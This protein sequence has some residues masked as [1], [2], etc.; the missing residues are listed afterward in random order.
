VE[1]VNHRHGCLECSVIILFNQIKGVNMLRPRN[2]KLIRKLQKLSNSELKHL[3][4]TNGRDK[5]R[6]RKGSFWAAGVEKQG[7]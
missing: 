1:A 4:V 7:F 6:G 3:M 5:V 2:P